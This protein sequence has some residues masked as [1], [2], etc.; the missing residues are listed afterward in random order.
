M[1]LFGYVRIYKP[2]LRICEYEQYKAVYCTLCK[3]LGRNYGPLSRMLLNYDFT[4]VALLYMALHKQLPC[5]ERKCCVF[6]PLKKCSYCTAEDKEGFSLTCA[7]TAEMYYHKLSDNVADSGWLASLGWRFLRMTAAPLRRKAKKRYP[8]LDALVEQCMIEQAA[9]EKAGDCSIDSAAEPSARLISEL[10]QMVAANDADRRVLKDFGYFFGRWIY[11][12]DAFDDMA[13]DVKKNSFNPF[14]A[15]FGLTKEDIE[16]NTELWS[17]ARLYANECLNMTVARALTAFSLLDTG[18]YEP[19]FENI[20]QLGLGEEQRKALN[21][22]ELH[23][24]EQSV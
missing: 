4:F 22:K 7:M 14:A 1:F 24:N 8:E 20:L 2:Q 21:E 18:V 12:I 11:L 13:D 3:E 16:N 17:Q 5:V 6:N 19:I 15:R 10:A 9:A 23:L